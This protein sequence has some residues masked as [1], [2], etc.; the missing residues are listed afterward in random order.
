MTEGVADG[1]EDGP[2]ERY[3]YDDEDSHVKV[4]GCSIVVTQIFGRGGATREGVP[5]RHLKQIIMHV[6]NHRITT[7]SIHIS[8]KILPYQLEP[9]ILPMLLPKDT[10]NAAKMAR[11]TNY[12]VLPWDFLDE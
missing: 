9:T 11:T 2:A 1:L 12:M 5:K 3:S 6:N 10:K 4:V 7:L 8:L